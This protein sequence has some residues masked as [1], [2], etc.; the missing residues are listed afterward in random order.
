[1]SDVFLKQ[2]LMISDFKTILFIVI[3]LLLAL[4]I[5]KLPKKRFSFSSKVIMGTIFG[6]IIGFSIQAVS[7]FNSSPMS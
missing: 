4:F 2:F 7:G 5:F 3:Y 1:M 6:L